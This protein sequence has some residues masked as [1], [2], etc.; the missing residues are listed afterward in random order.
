MLGVQSTMKYELQLQEINNKYYDKIKNAYGRYIKDFDNLPKLQ[1]CTEFVSNGKV[2]NKLIN[3]GN[4]AECIYR[5]QKIYFR[6]DVLFTDDLIIH[7]YIHLIAIKKTWYGKIYSGLAK[8]NFLINFNEILTEWIMYKIT[9]IKNHAR[10]YT[11]GFS[12]I[13]VLCDK[14][15]ENVIIECYFTGKVFPII[16]WAKKD[17][18]MFFKCF[19]TVIERSKNDKD[20]LSYIN[21]MTTY[22]SNK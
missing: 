10:P 8:Y 19:S 2:Y 18:F 6:T 1:D 4:S 5:N 22:F 15:G 14:I 3:S 21:L 9:G 20:I 7:E 12:L 17:T 16:R 11:Y 13:E